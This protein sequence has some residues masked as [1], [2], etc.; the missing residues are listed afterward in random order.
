MSKADVLVDL[1]EIEISAQAGWKELISKRDAATRASRPLLLLYPIFKHSKAQERSTDRVDLDAVGD[2]M[3]MAI[4][5]PKPKASVVLGYKRAKIDTY[6]DEEPEYT[7]E[8]LP[9][10]NVLP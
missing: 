4:V 5:F 3:G 8:S 6:V 1:P 2:I 7:E 10:D 9:G